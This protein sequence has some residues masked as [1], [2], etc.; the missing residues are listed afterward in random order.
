MKV[1]IF[2]IIAVAVSPLFFSV[3]SGRAA[4]APATP[5]KVLV[6]T[7]TLGFRHS[8]IPTAEK[9]ISQLAAKSGDFTVDFLQQPPGKPAAPPRPAALKPDASADEQTA[10][11]AAT[12]KYTTDMAAYKTAETAWEDSLKQALMKL[13]PDS[14]KNYDGLIF[15]STTG[16]LPI[17]DKEGL[18]A[19]IKAGHAFVA[20]HA[21]SDTFHHWPGYIDMLGGEFQNH[22][23]QVG[24][25]CIN[26]DPKHPAN[27]HLGPTLTIVQEEIYRFKN[28]DAAKEHELLFLDK[29]PNDKTP[30]HFPVSWCHAYGD[31]RVFYTSLGH[32][33][34]IW[35]GDPSLPGRVNPPAVSEAF[36]AHLLGGIRWTLGLTQS[37]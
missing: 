7:T 2:T 17:P 11:Q 28:Y 29:D 27:I 21:G 4:D 23:A 8:S 37:K 6:V 36:Q 26:A 5:K 32:R 30:G 14:L 31:G 9:I 25:D 18:L 35:D 34:D 20:I 12:T 3:I 24:V 10:F 19:W 15:C 16:D 13:S 33:E 1:S 22:K